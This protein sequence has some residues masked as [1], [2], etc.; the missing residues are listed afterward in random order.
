MIQTM[1]YHGVHREHGETRSDVDC[2]LCILLRDLCVSVVNF[3]P[4][5]DSP[6]NFC[7]TSSGAGA[8]VLGSIEQLARPWL[9]LRIALE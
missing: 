5:H 9:R 4:T 7:S 6:R 8:Y 3:L 1:I 2:N